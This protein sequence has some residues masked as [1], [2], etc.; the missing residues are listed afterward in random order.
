MKTETTYEDFQTGQANAAAE[1]FNRCE[2]H[3]HRGVH[4]CGDKIVIFGN[5]GASEPRAR[6][7]IELIKTSLANMGVPAPVQGL[8]EGGVTW[9]LLIFNYERRSYDLKALNAIV[10]AAWSKACDEATKE[11]EAVVS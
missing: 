4:D 11:K 3:Y 10:W 7:E 6:R 8:S 2:F 9:A 5:D 1:F